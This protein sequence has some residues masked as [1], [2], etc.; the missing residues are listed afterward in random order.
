MSSEPTPDVDPGLWRSEDRH[1]SLRVFACGHGD[2]ILVGL[3]GPRWGLIDCHLPSQDATKRF[4]DK[5]DTLEV[6]RLEF[7]ILTHPDSDHFLGM[8]DVLARFAKAGQPVPRFFDSGL[9][10]FQVSELMKAAGR[11]EEEI[12]EYARL[13]KSVALLGLETRVLN[14]GHC[15]I[16]VGGTPI[17]FTPIAPS[18]DWVLKSTR[19][20]LLGEDAD[21][22]VNGLSI[23]LVLA[24]ADPSAP[25]HM[26]L[27]ADARTEDMERASGVWAAKHAA[28]RA[29]GFSVV[30][31]PH[32]GSGNGHFPQIV[33][34]RKPASDN[35]AVVSVGRKYRL[36]KASVLRSYVE[37]GWHVL[38]TTVRHS[39]SGPDKLLTL[40]SAERNSTAP[41]TPCSQHDI[42]IT[43]DAE[44]GL[45]W[46]PAESRVLV[47]ALPNYF[48]D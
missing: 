37:A 45:S 39:P 8:A 40:F 17:S 2:M 12:A 26:L 28:G 9:G 6:E 42:C 46:T 22:D 18:E 32:H 47:A 43:W 11:P 13:I 44:E 48:P 36:P 4:F 3:P 41:T 29:P 19:A 23:V 30:K 1:V 10:W 33:H 5:L 7:V 31:I 34:Q 38:S 35:V 27:A 21:G 16:S 14:D 25:C 15:P 24:V 20:K